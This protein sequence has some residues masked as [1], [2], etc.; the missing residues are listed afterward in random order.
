MKKIVAYIVFSIISLAFV[1]AQTLE[2]KEHELYKKHKVSERIKINHKFVNGVVSKTGVKTSRSKYNKNGYLL[3][4]LTFGKKGDTVTVENFG[5]D[6]HGNR[7]FYER[8]S[9]S[10][11]YKKTSKYN[12]E[13]NILLESGYDGSA[14]FKTVYI[15]NN[16]GKI[17]EIKYY[18]DNMLDE[19]RVYSYTGNKAIVK[20]LHKGKTL[21]STIKLLFN[22]KGDI[23]EEVV[24]SLEGVELEKRI[25]NYNTNGLV[26]TEVKYRSGKLSY[27]LIYHYNSSKELIKLSEESTSKGKFDKK[28]YTYDNLRR[29]VEYKW[30]RKPDDKYNIKTYTYGSQG[31]CIKELTHYP[32]TNYKLLS[33]YQYKFH[34]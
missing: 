33:K 10:G 3:E 6:K 21:R 9:I 27:K 15:Y 12:E 2:E 8:K 13:D 26:N 28:L 23:V 25:L 18:A 30:K 20:I 24:L 16:A 34:K 19:K 11:V 14:A 31:V 5:Y 4:T 1:C 17:T 7:V 32:K 29:V 22:A